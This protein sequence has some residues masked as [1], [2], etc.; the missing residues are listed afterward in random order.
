VAFTLLDAAHSPTLKQQNTS[1]RLDGQ[2]VN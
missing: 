2:P 1:G